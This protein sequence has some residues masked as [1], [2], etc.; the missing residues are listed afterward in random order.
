MLDRAV[1][2][3]AVNL[4]N[5]SSRRS[6][7]GQLGR[8]IVALVGGPLVAVALTPDRAHAH[9]ICGHTYTTGSCPHPYA[10]LTRIDRYGYPV[11]PRY[12]YP[13]DD[14]GDIYVLPTQRRRRVCQERVAAIYPYTG[15]PVFGGAW[16][17]CC[18]RRIRRIYDCCSY[19]RRRINGD[20]SV[21]GYCYG[22]RRVFCILYR[23]TTISC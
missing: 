6:F 2:N 22:G 4:A 8:G 7:I 13:V 12:G 10:P 18:G 23:E 1:E 19:S 9:H 17:R 15:K 5:R 21:T 14:R 11:H 16:S 20:R 3:A